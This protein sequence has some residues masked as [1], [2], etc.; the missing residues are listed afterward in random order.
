MG[1]SKLTQ[2]NA[3][4]SKSK[5]IFS[6]KIIYGTEG[7]LAPETLKRMFIIEDDEAYFAIDVW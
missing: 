4:H 3:K 2:K 1:H 7:Y 6:S 5:S